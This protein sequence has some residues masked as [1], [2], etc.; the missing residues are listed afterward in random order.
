[1]VDMATFRLFVGEGRATLPPNVTSLGENIHSSRN[2]IIG[3]VPIRNIVRERQ[4]MT[5]VFFILS[6]YIMQRKII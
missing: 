3:L 4:K 1:M 2:H 6:Q 5:P